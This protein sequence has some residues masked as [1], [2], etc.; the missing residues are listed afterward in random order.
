MPEHPAGDF[1]R[2]RMV[3]E[4]ELSRGVSKEMRIPGQSGM[5]PHGALDLLGKGVGVLCTAAL[6]GKD[7][8]ASTIGE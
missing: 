2:A 4:D 3:V 6:P 8:R 7:C 5:G 1:V